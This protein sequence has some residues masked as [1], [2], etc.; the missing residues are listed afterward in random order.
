LVYVIEE[1]IRRFSFNFSDLA[2]RQSPP[3]RVVPAD[4]EPLPPGA[5]LVLAPRPPRFLG[6]LLP[7]IRQGE[8]LRV[9]VNSEAAPAFGARLREVL[10]TVFAA[11]GAPAGA[12]ASLLDDG[13]V[14]AFH[15][16]A[17]IPVRPSAELVAAELW[18]GSVHLAVSLLAEGTL[19]LNGAMPR[20]DRRLGIPA[21][22]PRDHI[23][24]L[25]LTGPRELAAMA[26]GRLP[27]GSLGRALGGLA[28]GLATGYR[29]AER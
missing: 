1:Q 14:V 2:P 26:T 24:R 15:E 20:L 10:A 21:H 7:F 6:S 18:P 17:T 25:P 28:A 3:L 5:R 13:F 4:S 12:C 23:V 9:R 29:E 27:P 16:L 8:C 11:A 22:L 19:V